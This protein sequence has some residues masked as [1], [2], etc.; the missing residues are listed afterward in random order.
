M[1]SKTNAYPAPIEER[2]FDK[3]AKEIE[4]INNELDRKLEVFEKALNHMGG[5]VGLINEMTDHMKNIRE[6]VS[7][8]V[9]RMSY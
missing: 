2:K 7:N 1:K 6:K 9:S 8:D 5:V 3:K 4:V